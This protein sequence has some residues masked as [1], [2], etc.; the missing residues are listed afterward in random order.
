MD[1]LWGVC[2]EYWEEITT[3]IQNVFVPVS[4]LCRAEAMVIYWYQGTHLLIWF[5]SILTWISNHMLSKM[6]DEITS[7]PEKNFN[8]AT[9]FGNL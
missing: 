1:E 7:F 5:N 9:V 6:W 8:G 2:Y 3:S 4:R